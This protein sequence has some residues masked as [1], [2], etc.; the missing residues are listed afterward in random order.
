M[1]TV[2]VWQFRTLSST[3]P[4]M[5]LHYTPESQKMQNKFYRII[6]FNLGT[7]TIT[8]ADKT[9]VHREGVAKKGQKWEESKLGDFLQTSFIDFPLLHEHN[10]HV[11]GVRHRSY[12]RIHPGARSLLQTLLQHSGKSTD[13]CNVHSANTRSNERPK[14]SPDLTESESDTKCTK[15][16]NANQLKWSGHL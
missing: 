14:C 6:C 5:L 9:D 2:T 15:C 1:C 4:L 16:R 12:Y 3:S 8:T 13:S 11:M 10:R 7:S